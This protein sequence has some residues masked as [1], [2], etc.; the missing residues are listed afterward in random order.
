MDDSDRVPA[1]RPV[2]I[3]LLII[4]A[5]LVLLADRT[6]VTGIHLSGGFWPLVL[7]AFGL[8]RLIAPPTERGGRPK[9]RRTGVWFVF[10]GCWFFVNEFH[11][12]GFDYGTS[13]PLLTVGAGVV[14][15]WRALENPG[16]G[17]HRV[18]ES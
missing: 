14:M 9:S 7:T 18:R 17:C 4:A 2:L 6:G 12:Y 5:G 16:G 10:L 8:A 3:G 11:F 1:R 15:V 13:W